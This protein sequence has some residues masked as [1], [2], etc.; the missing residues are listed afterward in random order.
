MYIFLSF[1]LVISSLVLCYIGDTAN[2]LIVLL[3]DEV[4]LTERRSWAVD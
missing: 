3:M 1:V 2:D 4:C